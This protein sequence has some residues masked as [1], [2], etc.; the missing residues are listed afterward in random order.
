MKTIKTRV[1]ALEE[2][3][4]T[5]AFLIVWEDLEKPGYWNVN[6]ENITWPEVEE[7]YSNREIIKVVYVDDWRADGN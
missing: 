4:E 3:N 2:R 1:E 5:K 6:G 7:R